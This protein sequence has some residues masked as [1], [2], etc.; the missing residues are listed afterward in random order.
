MIPMHSTT[1]VRAAYNPGGLP[2]LTT[3]VGVFVTISGKYELEIR[4][5]WGGHSDRSSDDI[6][7]ATL[8]RFRAKSIEELVPLSHNSL[9]EDLRQQV[10]NTVYDAEDIQAS[11]V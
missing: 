8:L 9:D 2:F 6:S 1:I 4:Q 3:F 7:T 5:V 11:T 10:R